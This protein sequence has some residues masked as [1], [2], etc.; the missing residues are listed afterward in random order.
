MSFMVSASSV[1]AVLSL[2]ACE[3]DPLAPKQYMADAIE[4]H[5]VGSIDVDMVGIASDRVVPARIYFNAEAEATAHRLAEYARWFSEA[6]RGTRAQLA[7]ALSDDDDADRVREPFTFKGT[8]LIYIRLAERGLGWTAPVGAFIGP[9][10]EAPGADVEQ[11]DGDVTA[12]WSGPWYHDHCCGTPGS[13]EPLGSGCD[14]LADVGGYTQWNS[15][16]GTFI[17]KEDGS[18]VDDDTYASGV[19]TIDLA[20][21]E[22]GGSYSLTAIGT[23]PGG[24]LGSGTFWCK[25]H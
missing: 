10:S 11:V 15:S 2:S 8:K 17:L 20:H 6:D 22:G 13:N 23:W 14:D 16:G 12:Q 19:H 3:A 18:N 1:V 7:N 5:A 4:K 24:I 21:D 25:E 9:K